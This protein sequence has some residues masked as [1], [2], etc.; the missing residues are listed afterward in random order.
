MGF[1]ATALLSLP[2]ERIPPGVGVRTQVT[3][4]GLSP[5]FIFILLAVPGWRWQASC[6][7]RLLVPLGMAFI[8]KE[9]VTVNPRGRRVVPCCAVLC[10]A[11]LA[12]SSSPW[13]SPEVIAMPWDLLPGHPAVPLWP[14]SKCGTF[15]LPALPQVDLCPAALR[16]HLPG[17]V[18]HSRLAFPV[19]CRQGSSSNGL[20]ESAASAH[21]VDIIG[22]NKR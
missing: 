16:G 6:A 17:F 9:A 15:P 11:V 7:T 20:S 22:M 13:I 12:F 10:H 3:S 2:C 8:L 19:A 21:M 5:W 1:L 18:P 4:K 14:P